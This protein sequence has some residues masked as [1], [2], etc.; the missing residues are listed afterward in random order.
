LQCTVELL[1]VGNELLLGNTVNT[2][3][4]WIAA[5]VTL[6][7]GKVTRITTVADDREEI[8]AAVREAIRRGPSL[9]ITTGG[10]GPTFDDMTLKCIGAAFRLRLRLDDDALAM[11]RAHY[12]RRFPGK[13]MALTKSRVKMA[14]IPKG[15]IPLRN[16]VGTAPGV[17][18][19]VKGIE[20]FVL[21][22]VPKEAKAI[23][24]R[25]VAKA[26]TAKAGG[27]VFLE[28][29]ILVRGIMESALAPMIDRTMERWPKVYIKSHPRG[30]EAGKSL[31]ELHFSTTSENKKEASRALRE[32]ASSLSTQLR[33]SHVKLLQRR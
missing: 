16:P 8:V 21:P 25:S 2:N 5:Q 10:I 30:A 26:V 20:V 27:T 18:L 14:L 32:A 15:S 6:L 31:I 33:S 1:S 9:L 13:T 17:M 12:A 7:G 3:A 22:G 24:R 11:I 28:K 29:W 4:S 23:F 19:M